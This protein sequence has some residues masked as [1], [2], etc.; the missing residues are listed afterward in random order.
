APEWMLSNP[1]RYPRMRDAGGAELLLLSPVAPA[2]L[3]ADKK[4]F[5]AMMRHLKKTDAQQQTVIMVQVQNEAGSLGTDRDYSEG[6]NAVFNAPVPAKL[7]QQ[8]GKNTGTWK[9]V[10]GIDAPE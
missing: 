3:D 4:A 9:E 5:A 8:L 1:D 6:A 10:F 7:V 2:N